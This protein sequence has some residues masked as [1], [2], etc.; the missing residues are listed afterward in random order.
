MQELSG[1]PRIFAVYIM[2]GPPL[3]LSLVMSSSFPTRHSQATY[4]TISI[5]T[6]LLAAMSTGN[7]RS[8]HRPAG[9][10][11]PM[12]AHTSANVV[13]RPESHSSVQSIRGRTRRVHWA[14]VL[15]IESDCPPSTP[16]EENSPTRYEQHQRNTGL[17]TQSSLRRERAW[18]QKVLDAG[19]WRQL[20]A[21]ARQSRGG[22]KARRH[23]WRRR[24]NGPSTRPPNQFLDSYGDVEFPSLERLFAMTAAEHK[25]LERALAETNKS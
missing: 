15:T 13:S 21:M 10:T 1:P 20:V 14:D 4:I 17:G 25:E 24:A 12:S 11:E 5:Q 23:R 6:K 8:S 9:E 22:R 19:G 18:T 7:D 2:P 16:I 3:P